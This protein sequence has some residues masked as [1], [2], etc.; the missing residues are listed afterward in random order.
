VNAETVG[1]K[2]EQENTAIDHPGWNNF[3][4]RRAA[5]DGDAWKGRSQ[6]PYQGLCI[7]AYGE[8]YQDMG[9]RAGPDCRRQLGD[10]AVQT[11]ALAGG[12]ADAA[13]V[14]P[15]LNQGLFLC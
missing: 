6:E 7:V 3:A 11:G 9:V 4:S 14:C 12:D 5:R 10:R 8:E 13:G 1:G 2:R 15:S